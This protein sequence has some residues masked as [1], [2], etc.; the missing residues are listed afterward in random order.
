MAEAGGA[1]FALDDSTGGIDEADG[2]AAGSGVTGGA[3]ATARFVLAETAFEGIAIAADAL[4]DDELARRATITP[5][6]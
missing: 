2:V 1:A 5:R 4:V 3:D 6:T